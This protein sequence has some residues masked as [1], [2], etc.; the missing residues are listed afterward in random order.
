MILIGQYDSP[1]VRRVA[2]A[3]RLLAIDFEHRPW[4]V[5]ADAVRLA[6]FNPLRRVPTLVLDDGTVL[7]ES[8]VML[9]VIDDR[10]GPA[11]A[12]LPRSGATRL[13]G[14][15]VS[16]FAVGVADKAV[17]L[18]YEGV[19]RTEAS[20]IWTERCRAQILETLDLLERER[21]A[22]STTYW[23]GHTISHPDIAIACALRFVQEGLPGLLDAPRYP[24]LIRDAAACEALPAFIEIRQPITVTLKR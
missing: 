18:F 21:A 11:R 14:L 5:W 6:A 10:V 4:S 13:Q 24:T 12:L 2:V 7:V 15:R 23:L 9:D 8:T 22:S 19:L 3:L 16:A 20:V 1:F 17:S